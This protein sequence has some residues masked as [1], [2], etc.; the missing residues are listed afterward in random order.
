MTHDPD[1]LPIAADLL[2]PELPEGIPKVYPGTAPEGCGLETGR[3]NST[4]RVTGLDG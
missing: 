3:I 2:V 1:R 4:M